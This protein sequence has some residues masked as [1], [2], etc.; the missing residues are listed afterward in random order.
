[1]FPGLKRD[2]VSKVTLGGETR[3]AAFASGSSIGIASHYSR[4]I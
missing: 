4:R 3:A 1:M 2:V